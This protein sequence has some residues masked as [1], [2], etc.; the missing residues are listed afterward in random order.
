VRAGLG[1]FNYDYYSS[2]FESDIFNNMSG[3]KN[4]NVNI[5]LNQDHPRLKVSLPASSLNHAVAAGSAT[6]GGYLALKVAQNTPGSHKSCCW[7]SNVLICSRNYSWF[8]KSF[9]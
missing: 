2:L 4:T 6:G 8:R 3:D 1:L 7:F 9:E 5:N